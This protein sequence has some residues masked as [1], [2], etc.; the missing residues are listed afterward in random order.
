MLQLDGEVTLKG[1][2]WTFFTLTKRMKKYYK[3][4]LGLFSL[5]LCSSMIVS[6]F[7]T[8][9][10]AEDRYDYNE[11]N[12]LISEEEHNQ[13]REHFEN[14]KEERQERAIRVHNYAN[15]AL[16][17]R[18]ITK[19]N[20][21]V[22]AQVTKTHCGPASMQMVLKFLTNTK[23]DQYTLGREMGM[24]SNGVTIDAMY[25]M[26]NQHSDVSYDI[27]YASEGILDED[28]I[29]N[30]DQGYPLT[31][32]V[33]TT[34]LDGWNNIDAKHHIVGYGYETT[35]RGIS[36]VWYIDPYNPDEF[37]NVAVGDTY[38]KKD[39]SYSDLLETMKLLDN[40][41]GYYL[42]LLE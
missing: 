11:E 4:V 20:V 38:G 12:S 18:A 15:E 9:I 22:Y 5:V 7:S 1:A 14:T 6:L 16:K 28:I 33:N 36:N 13:L 24:T 10:K 41:D 30:I 32:D 34:L 25:R 31:Y 29:Y 42:R 21:P 40:N 39:I 19:L 23:F 3:I 26:I 2:V 37:K 17:K 27:G 8:S 35:S